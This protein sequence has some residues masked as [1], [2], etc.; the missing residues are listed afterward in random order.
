MA[1]SGRAG[2]RAVV[3]GLFA[4]VMDAELCECPV[5]PVNRWQLP[6]GA[7]TAGV[8]MGR[9]MHMGVAGAERAAMEDA[10]QYAAMGAV[11][12]SMEC[13]ACGRVFAR[14]A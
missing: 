2:R 1:D 10:A 14:G 4:L 13:P 7:W 11:A 3:M 9:Y 12:W 8:D 6:T 5:A